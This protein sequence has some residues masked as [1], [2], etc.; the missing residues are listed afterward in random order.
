[1]NEWLLTALILGS[2]VVMYFRGR[3]DGVRMAREEIIGTS[4]EWLRKYYPHGVPEHARFDLDVIGQTI[5]S[6]IRQLEKSINRTE[7]KR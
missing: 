5:E 6:L 3:I 1:M 7:T 2:N 4:K